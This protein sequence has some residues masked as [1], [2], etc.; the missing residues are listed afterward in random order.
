MPCFWSCWF[1]SRISNVSL[2]LRY[3]CTDYI[4]AKQN[5]RIW[6]VIM[7]QWFIIISLHLSLTRTAIRH[8]IVTTRQSLFGSLMWHLCWATFGFKIKVST[9]PRTPSLFLT[10][11]NQNGW[12][13]S[14]FSIYFWEKKFPCCLV[15]FTLLSSRKKVVAAFCWVK[16]IS[17]C[18]FNTSDWFSFIGLSW[19]KQKFKSSC[20]YFCK[21]ITTFMCVLRFCCNNHIKF[22]FIVHT[23]N[24]MKT[25]WVIDWN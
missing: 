12:I 3:F 5:P 25:W 23:L 10:H 7:Q 20:N 16:V 4:P 21:G 6:F 13:F 17:W 9:R 14:N 18:S 11:W 24:I 8:N 19:N 1:I 22:S 15:N 2:Y